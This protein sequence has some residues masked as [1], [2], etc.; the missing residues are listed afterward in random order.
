MSF[1]GPNGTSSDLISK[2]EAFVRKLAFRIEY[3]KNKKYAMLK[4]LTSVEDNSNDEFSE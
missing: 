3:V 1:Q 2:L 4:L